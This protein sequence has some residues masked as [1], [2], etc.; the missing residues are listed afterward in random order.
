MKK[1]ILH[2]VF[3]VMAIIL[4]SITMSYADDSL[5]INP[6]SYDYSPSL[7]W[8]YS[9]TW[10]DEEQESIFERFQG[11]SDYELKDL[12]ENPDNWGKGWI[13]FV[14][15]SQWNELV[16]SINPEYYEEFREITDRYDDMNVISCGNMIIDNVRVDHCEEIG[17]YPYYYMMVKYKEDNNTLSSGSDWY[18]EFIYK[19]T[20]NPETV[21]CQKMKELCIYADMYL[22]QKDSIQITKDIS[23]SLIN[24]KRTGRPEDQSVSI[25]LL[26]A[27]ICDD[28][29]IAKVIECY[30]EYELYDRQHK[31]NTISDNTWNVYQLDLSVSINDA[32]LIPIIYYIEE[33]SS[34]DILLLGYD[35]NHAGCFIHGPVNDYLLQSYYLLT[36]Y[37]ITDIETGDIVMHIPTEYAGYIAKN[38]ND[39][40]MY[41]GIPMEVVIS[42]DD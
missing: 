25:K 23:I 32:S 6:I 33:Q 36:R 37:K 4:S 1:A 11:I 28:V 20:D 31:N 40:I 27:N 18:L 29:T 15:S 24:T 2:I 7:D 26:N 42:V 19:R 21:L 35:A 12:Y 17:I 8:G 34:N 14:S 30:E 10:F 3:I 39:S 5:I 22:L 13:H 16:E 9:T 38:K 41:S